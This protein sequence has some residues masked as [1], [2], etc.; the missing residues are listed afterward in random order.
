VG[1]KPGPLEAAPEVG[2]LTR[3]AETRQLDVEPLR[4]ELS[5][6]V[7]NGLRASDRDDGDALGVEIPTT[8]LGERFERAPV[9]GPLDKDGGT[10]SRRGRQAR[11]RIVSARCRPSAATAVSLTR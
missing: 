6:E 9:A 5:E 1:A 10:Q 8:A 2:F 3:V 11:N 7:S 4:A